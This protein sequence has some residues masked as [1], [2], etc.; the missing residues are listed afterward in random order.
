M[1]ASL[2]GVD[3]ILDNPSAGHAGEPNNLGNRIRS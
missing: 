2:T 3:S 1:M